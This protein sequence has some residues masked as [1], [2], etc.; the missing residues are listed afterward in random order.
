MISPTAAPRTTSPSS[1]AAP[2]GLSEGSGLRARLRRFAVASLLGAAVVV[3]PA[4]PTAA[5]ERSARRPAFER[6]LSWRDFIRL[7]LSPWLLMQNAQHPEA[8]DHRTDEWDRRPPA[9]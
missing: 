4:W 2:S 9:R 1:T 7:R 6:A 3:W 5:Q 8:W